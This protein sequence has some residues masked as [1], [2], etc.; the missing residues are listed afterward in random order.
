[1]TWFWPTWRLKR[2]IRTVNLEQAIEF[3]KEGR[4]VLLCHPHT[5]NLEISARAFAVLG[6]P[7]V[8]YIA[9]TT[10]QRTTL[11]SIGVEP[12]TVTS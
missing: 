12:T 4:G 5:L 9:R 8:A 2:R 11:S 1:M 3:E 10:T 7:A 6:Y